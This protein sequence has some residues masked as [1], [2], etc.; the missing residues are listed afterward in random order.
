MRKNKFSEH[1]IIAILKAVSLPSSEQL[2]TRFMQKKNA[3][4]VIDVKDV[5]ITSEVS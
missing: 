2:L 3:R 1:Q 4:V 5:Q